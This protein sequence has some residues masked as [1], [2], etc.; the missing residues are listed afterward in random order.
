MSQYLI[1]HIGH[2]TKW[3]EHITWWKPESMGYCFGLE[4]AGIYSEAKARGICEMSGLCIAVPPAEARRLAQST[5]YY[6]G[7]GGMLAPLYDGMPLEVVPNSPAAW[8][9]LSMA[10]LQCERKPDK[11]TPITAS[12]SRAIYLPA[13]LIAP[14]VAK[15]G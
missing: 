6:R 8:R 1:A 9:A 2:T 15:E 3:C 5:P 12:R 14:P 4:K 11:P 10:A 13:D 7:P